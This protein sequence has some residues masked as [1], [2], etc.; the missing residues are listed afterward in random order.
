LIRALEDRQIYYEHLLVLPALIAEVVVDL[1]SE[2]VNMAEMTLNDLEE[3]MRQHPYMNGPLELDFLST[4]RQINLQSRKLGL[5]TARLRMSD[6]Q[7]S[8]TLSGVK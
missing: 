4:I 6:G 2:G 8:R 3:N 1:F 7:K 5:D